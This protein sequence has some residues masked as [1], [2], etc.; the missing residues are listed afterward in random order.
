MILILYLHRQPKG[1]KKETILGDT[2]ITHLMS[3]YSTDDEII[4]L[5]ME[6]NSNIILV[7]IQAI[8]VTNSCKAQGFFTEI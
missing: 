7:A 8:K 2:E 1:P 5:I 3:N 6:G 4:R